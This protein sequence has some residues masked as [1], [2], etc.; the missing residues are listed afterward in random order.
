MSLCYGNKGPF[1]NYICSLFSFHL[2]SLIAVYTLSLLCRYMYNICFKS[3]LDDK[4]ELV[5]YRQHSN[6]FFNE[7]KIMKP[8]SIMLIYF[9]QISI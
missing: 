1:I 6:N 9:S 4:V 5:E 8:I 7:I 2:L 3:I